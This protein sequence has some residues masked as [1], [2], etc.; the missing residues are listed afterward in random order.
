M[1]SPDP[2]KTS[3]SELSYIERAAHDRAVLM[4]ETHVKENVKKPLEDID[5]KLKSI[6]VWLRW[7]FGAVVT[8]A[9]AVAVLGAGVYGSLVNYWGGDAMFYG[10]TSMGTA[11]L[12]FIAGWIARRR[13]QKMD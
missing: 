10:A 12:G 1:S 13:G 2:A 11:L 8:L 7:L 3:T 9:L 4:L 6:R 5:K